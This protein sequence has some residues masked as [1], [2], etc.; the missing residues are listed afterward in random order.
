MGNDCIVPHG[1]AIAI[2]IGAVTHREH[3]ICIK[4]G[5]LEMR[6]IMTHAEYE[7]VYALLQRMIKN[8]TL[9]PKGITE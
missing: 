8:N 7:T 2:G 4:V 5:K 9:G 3:E 1:H 6:E